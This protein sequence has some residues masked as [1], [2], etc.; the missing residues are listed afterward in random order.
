MAG[1]QTQYRPRTGGTALKNMGARAAS[2]AP[3]LRALSS[4]RADASLA[5]PL[6]STAFLAISIIGIKSR[7]QR[8]GGGAAR[9]I[10]YRRAVRRRA[11]R[12]RKNK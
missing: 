6:C 3:H 11:H 5:D 1:A 12:G 9:L 10:W 7:G 2:R 4:R 8:T